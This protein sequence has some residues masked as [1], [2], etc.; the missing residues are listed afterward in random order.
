MLRE[1]TPTLPEITSIKTQGSGDDGGIPDLVAYDARG[2]SPLLG[3]AKF[4]AGLTDHQPVTYLARL[5]T[6]GGA[7]LLVI[8]P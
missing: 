6:D 1:S 4:D 3:E 5:P 7:V 8:A 2:R